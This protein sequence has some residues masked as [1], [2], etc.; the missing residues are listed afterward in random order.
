MRF[1]QPMYRHG[2]LVKGIEL[3]FADGLITKA[4]ATENEELLLSML[5]QPNAN[6]VGEYSLTDKRL[7]PITKFMADILYD[8]NT[9]GEYG[10]THIAVGS[11][12]KDAYTG[13]PLEQVTPDQREALGFNDSV[14]HTDLISTT[15]RKVTAVCADGS[16]HCIYE[17]G[18]F[19]FPI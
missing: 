4:S 2:S 14:E 13:G 11:A 7:S 15:K 16:S 10:N 17:D 3:T 8:E 18:Q 9:G 5:Q 6:K 1:N 12:Y 19:T